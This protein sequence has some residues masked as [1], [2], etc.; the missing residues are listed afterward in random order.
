MRRACAA[1]AF[2][3]LALAAGPDAR[4]TGNGAACGTVVVS[5]GFAL[6]SPEPIAT[7]DP[8]L[9]SNSLA[10][11]NGI[12][13]LYLPLLW[14]DGDDHVD[15]S[16]SLASAVVP[17]ADDTSF[18]VSLRPWHWSDGTAVT[19]AD[20]LYAWTLIRSLGP[21]FYGWD[22]GGVPQ[23]IRTVTAPDPR[24]LV[25]TLRQRVNPD[26]FEALGLDDFTPLPRQA[27][28]RW[29]LAEQQSRQSQASFYGV[30]DGPFRIRSLALGRDAVF[31]PNEHYEGPHPGYRRLV[32]DFF[33]GADPI[34]RLRAGQ[35]DVVNFPYDLWD[36]ASH[37]PGARRVDLGAEGD[38]TTIALNFHNPGVAFLGERP[39]RQ[40]IARAIDQRRIID[41]VYH[42]RSLP[43]EGFIATAD[44]VR[45]PPELRGGSGP[46]S[47][48]PAASRALLDRAG[49]R[50]GIDG[51]RTRNGHR[52][53]LTLLLRSDDATQILM[54]E[55]IQ[56]D[57]GKVGIAVALKEVAFNQLI[58]RMVGARQGWDAVLIPWGS[59]NYP[60][61]TQWFSPTSAGNYGGYADPT[62]DRLLDAATSE[63][64]DGPLFALE[65]YVVLQQPMIFLPSGNTIVLARDGIGGLATV[66]GPS[67]E[68]NAE[69]LTAACGN[70]GA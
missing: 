2:A 31:V 68:L 36:A 8:M 24:T 7:L 16:K 19:S 3:A 1:S 57:L 62:M 39:V 47:F 23:L 54:A 30:V 5:A 37:L 35:L 65:R 20:A 42:G 56:T 26:W 59:G 61:G 29:S 15:W 6:G 48:D 14:F 12:T 51:I 32:M 22:T 17:N 63:A 55:L 10:E 33:E 50:P 46:M 69:R 9:T 45:I 53:A 70:P 40:A 27:W 52:L 49:W 28:S 21:S 60:D 18:T 66:L 44:A 11:W 4:A 38:I 64:G 34:E 43:Q 13:L 67:G 58:A 41:T 25:V